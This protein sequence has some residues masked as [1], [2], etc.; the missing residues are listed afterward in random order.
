MEAESADAAGALG[1]DTGE[2][3]ANNMGAAEFLVADAVGQRL[4][5]AGRSEAA[6]AMTAFFRPAARLDDQSSQALP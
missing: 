1:G 5:S 3:A 2:L 4:R 6:A